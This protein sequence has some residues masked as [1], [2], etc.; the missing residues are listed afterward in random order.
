MVI[1]NINYENCT[2]FGRLTICNLYPERK[3]ETTTFFT[4]EIISE[5]NPFLTRKWEADFDIDLLHWSKFSVHFKKF[6]T[7]FND[8]NFDYE[9]LLNADAVFMR[10]KELLVVPRGTTDSEESE[11][12]SFSGFYYICMDKESGSIEGYYYQKSANVND[13]GYQSL[14]LDFQPDEFMGVFQIR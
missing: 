13:S 7:T 12:C 8:D 10:W 4:G 9:A 5:K 14:K 3:S 1:D 6:E 11:I 2:L